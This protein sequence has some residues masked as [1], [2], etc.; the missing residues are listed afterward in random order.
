MLPSLTFYDTLTTLI[1]E[2]KTFDR[3][4]MKGLAYSD[5]P[6]C[7]IGDA[8]GARCR[9]HLVREEQKSRLLPY[10]PMTQE[11]LSGLGLDSAM[12][13]D[14]AQIQ[15]N[16]SNRPSWHDLTDA[17]KLYFKIR[18]LRNHWDAPMVRLKDALMIV[19]T[20]A[21][22]APKDTRLEEMRRGILHLMKLHEAGSLTGD[23]LRETLKRYRTTLATFLT[24][25]QQDTCDSA[26]LSDYNCTHDCFRPTH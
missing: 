18:C 10:L 1:S 14:I 17:Q 13:R 24:P 6:L 2:G 4:S 3:A 20:L 9:M 5:L 25:E 8:M 19:A 11:E 26:E 21:K 12:L 22:E 15:A 16:R 7:A 23:D